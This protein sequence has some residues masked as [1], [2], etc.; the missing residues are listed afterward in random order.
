MRVPAGFRDSLTLH[1]EVIWVRPTKYGWNPY[2]YCPS[3][4]WLLVAFWHTLHCERLLHALIFINPHTKLTWTCLD[5]YHLVLTTILNLPKCLCCKDLKLQE[6]PGLAYQVFMSRVNQHPWAPPWRMDGV[7]DGW[8]VDT[9]CFLGK[10]NKKVFPVHPTGC[11]WWWCKKLG[12]QL[13]KSWWFWWFELATA[14]LLAKCPSHWAT[15]KATRR[16]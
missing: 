14:W 9:K 4:D 10:L 3:S 11:W 15:I 16:S 6:K 12:W 13:P 8:C 7:L 1:L 2:W 5:K